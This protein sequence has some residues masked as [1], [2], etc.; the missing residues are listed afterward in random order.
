[1]V[2]GK[3]EKRQRSAL[4]DVALWVAQLAIA[5]VF[6][7]VG[8]MKVTIPIP[9]LGAMM[10]WA[11]ELPSHFV[12]AVGMIDIAGG[13]GILL[14]ALT[15]VKPGLTVLAAVGCVAL[16]I[17]AIVFHISRGE[18]M[19]APFNFVLLA[20]AGFVLWGRRGPAPIH[21]RR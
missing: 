16:Q 13:I 21:A 4:L 17:C 7:M 1:M 12:R 18:A 15:R 20:L 2:A 5:M 14:P 10:P 9:E 8:W 6:V 11:E 19:M 3:N